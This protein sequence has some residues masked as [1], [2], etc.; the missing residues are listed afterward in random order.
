MG[1]DETLEQA[2]DFGEQ[3]RADEVAVSVVD[4]LEVVEVDEGEAEGD[5][6]WIGLG[7]RGRS[8]GEF[9]LL[10]EHGVEVAGVEEAGAVV[11]DGE[12]VDEVDGACVADG[13]GG[14]VAEDAQEGDGVFAEEIELG[15][16]ELDDAEGFLARADGDACDGVDVEVGI[17]AGEAG[18][19]GVE[20][21]VGNDERVSGG[22]DPAGYSRAHGDAEA[23]EGVG[24]FADGDGV[25][26][27]LGGLVD[28]EEGP[29]LGAEE[30]GHLVHD[31]EEDFFEFEGGREGAGDVVE[32]AQV[33]HLAGFDD[34][35]LAALHGRCGLQQT[36]RYSAGGMCGYYAEVAWRQGV[37]V[38]SS[39]SFP[40]SRRRG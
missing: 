16:E 28:H 27:V 19:V 36:L 33:I 2:A 11:G 32:D 12:L 9:Y 13:D 15:V 5:G 34:F 8:L 6:D 26:E 3:A 18:P 38:K 4:V 31:G 1:T 35:E 10:L 23:F 37:G 14:V 29:A 22:G 7:A 17:L 21:D 24:I 40:G 25:V 30:G 39:E 20:R